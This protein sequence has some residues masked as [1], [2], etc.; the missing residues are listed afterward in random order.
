MAPNATVVPAALGS[1]EGTA[2]LT[3]NSLYGC[4]STVNGTPITVTTIDAWAKRANLPVNFIKGDLESYE[5]EVL[6]G[7]SASIEADKPRIA[8]TVYHP[9]N[10]WKQMAD[11]LSHLVPEYKFRI[12]GISYNAGYPRP[13]ML[14]A[15]AD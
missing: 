9:G 10:D 2:F 13:V 15:W 12:K 8:F 11:F 3:G 7:A 1:C 6:K 14:H 5:F 4:I